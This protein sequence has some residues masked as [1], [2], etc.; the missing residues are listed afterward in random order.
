MSDQI[1]NVKIHM[2]GDADFSQVDASLNKLTASELKLKD[3]LKQV[4]TQ[5]KATN[6]TLQDETQKSAKA[7]SESGK[8]FDDLS[9]KVKNLSSQIPGAFHV[10]QVLGFAKAATGA[11][12]AVGGT[13]AA[14][15]V[16][17]VAFAS[18]GIGAL[19]IALVSLVAYFQKTDEGATK[20]EGIM[21]GLN[22]AF[23]EIV[24]YVAEFGS[25]VFE[26]FESVTNFQDALSELGDFILNNILNRF[27]SVLVLGD[28]ISK[29]FKGDFVGASKAAVDAFVQLQTGI[30]NMTGK[31]SD[32][33]DRIAKAAQEAYEYAIKLDAVN[34]AQ[35]EFNVHVSENNIK[36]V[37]LIRQ[38]KNHSLAI[39][40]RIDKLKE[41]N[42]ID[43]QSLQGQL[44]IENRRLKLIQDRNEESGMP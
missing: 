5:A 8:S 2:V 40:E 16:L 34:D 12:S 6:K 38:S 37:E 20:L 4:D 28:A 13:S 36:V 22:A 17:K 19:L 9:G 32:F 35:R 1:Q 42:K 11:T 29:L 25:A 27:K 33:A 14:M 21:G 7:V 18:T 10:E 43:S 24:G 30:T 23:G 44:D 3:G 26:A 41:A 15:N 31:A 39:Q